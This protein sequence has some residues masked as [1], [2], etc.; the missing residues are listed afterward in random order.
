MEFMNTTKENRTGSLDS[1]IF[2]KEAQPFDIIVFHY[3]CQDGLSSAYVSVLAH[4]LNGWDNPE[5]YP[6]AHGVPIDLDRLVGKCVLFCDYSP[7]LDVLNQIEQVAESIVVLDHHVTA[8]DDLVSKPYAIFDMGRSGVGITWD[9]FFPCTKIPLYLSMI[10]D[11]DLWVWKVPESKNFCSGFFQECGSID[12]Y[13]FVELFKL[14]DELYNNP[15]SIERY[16]NMGS[17]LEKSTARKVESIAQGALKKIFTYQDKRVCI[18]NCTGEFI[19]ELGNVISSSPDVDFAVLWRHNAVTNDYYVSLRS[20]GTKADVSAI[21][22][23]FGGGGHPNAAGFT[24]HQ[25][26]PY[27]LFAKD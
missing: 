13:D 26:N 8:R 6:I 4:R 15:D 18:V 25:S 7:K 20:C 16:I 22:A 12:S 1:T 27:D 10:Q 23:S 2:I 14:F 5:L 3:P 19:S 11:R 17:T 24:I 21:A 9:Y